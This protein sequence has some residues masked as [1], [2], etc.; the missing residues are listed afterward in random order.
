MNNPAGQSL[1]YQ[2]QQ[3]AAA[4]SGMR[5]DELRTAPVRH[6]LEQVI[7][8]LAT[9]FD[10]LEEFG[11]FTLDRACARICDNLGEGK[12]ERIRTFRHCGQEHA[13][14]A[15]QQYVTCP[16]CKAYRIKTSRLFGEDDIREAAYAVLL[17]LQID[18]RTIP[19]WNRACDNERFSDV[20]S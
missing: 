15:L 8:R 19:G 5:G 1:Q 20:R 13:Y 16:I 2:L 18:P 17:W 10:L 11:F 3:L 9:N 7:D 14:H 4:L 12:P 6:L